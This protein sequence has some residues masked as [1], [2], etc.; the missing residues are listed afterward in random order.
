MP[1]RTATATWNGP[2]QGGTGQMTA[3]SGAFNLS[4]SAGTRFGEDPGT[5]PEELIGAAHAGCFSMAL[6][7]ALGQAGH[8]PNRIETTARVRIE[9]VEG[10]FR[11]TRIE[12]DTQGDVPGIDEQ[13]FRQFAEQAKNGCP[14]SQALRGVDEVVL[15]A[16]LA[17]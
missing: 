14:V 9:Q 5:N 17:G 8:Q 12:L 3:G 1:V 7:F 10:G 11:I 6:A 13:T 2:L 15:S 4:F 16:R